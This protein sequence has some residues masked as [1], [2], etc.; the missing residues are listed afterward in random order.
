MKGLSEQRTERSEVGSYLRVY[1]KNILGQG[2]RNCSGC[3]VGTGL[4]W[5]RA[6]G[7]RAWSR[8]SDGDSGR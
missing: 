6:A 4:A 5:L 2:N 8:A 7:Q 1:A 3:E